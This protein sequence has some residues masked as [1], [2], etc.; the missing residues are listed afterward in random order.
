M[1]IHPTTKTA[2]ISEFAVVEAFRHISDSPSRCAKMLQLLLKQEPIDIWPFAEV[3]MEY[4]LKVLDESVPRYLQDLYKDVWLR[5][6]TVLPRK[7]W[8]LTVKYLVGFYTAMDRVDVA[9]D[10]LQ[11]SSYTY[12]SPSLCY[13]IIFFLDNAL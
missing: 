8:V 2:R 9:E 12:P 11:V 7:L 6:N 5:L 1:S 4:A 3:F 13:Y 10:P